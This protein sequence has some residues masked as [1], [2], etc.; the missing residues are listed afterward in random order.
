MTR[1]IANMYIAGAIP[2]FAQMPNDPWQ[3][4]NDK[5]ERFINEGKDLEKYF[6]MYE[7]EIEFLLRSHGRDIQRFHARNRGK[8]TGIDEAFFGGMKDG[9]G[10]EL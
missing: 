8:L 3:A 6:R 9:K 7:I 10:F 1:N 2:Y 5:L 4:A